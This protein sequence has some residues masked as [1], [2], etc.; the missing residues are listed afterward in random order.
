YVS[1][2]ELFTHLY[3]REKFTENEVRIYIGEIILAL[4]HLH[5]LGWQNKSENLREEDAG[6]TGGRHGP[7]SASQYELSLGYCGPW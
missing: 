7:L 3:Q 6:R 5:K 2:G 1:G 4:E